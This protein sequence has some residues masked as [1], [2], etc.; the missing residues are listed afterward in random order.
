MEIY[1]KTKQN[2]LLSAF[3]VAPRSFQRRRYTDMYAGNTEAKRNMCS[4]THFV[5]PCSTYK[6][7][8]KS[9]SI[10]YYNFTGSVVSE[11]LGV[12]AEG[13]KE[14]VIRDPGAKDKL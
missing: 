12:S 11:K 7:M 5:F 14:A 9:S 10:K 8:S 3:A 6:C 2:L 13:M 1:S 4:S